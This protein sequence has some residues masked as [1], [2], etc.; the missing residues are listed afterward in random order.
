MTKNILTSICVFLALQSC[1]DTLL[2]EDIDEQVTNIE[3][4]LDNG[5]FDYTRE[6]D[7]FKVVNP[8]TPSTQISLQ[9]GDSLYFYFAQYLFTSTIGALYYT[10]IEHLATEANMDLMGLSYEPL[11]VK[12]GTTPLIEGYEIGL[13]GAMQGDTLTLFMTS[14]LAYGDKYISTLDKNQSI[15]SV[16]IIEKIVK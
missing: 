7:L 15:A 2:Q 13:N 12:Y 11:A 4:Y 1:S 10:N 16:V 6:G 3:S 5:K 8:V 14:E 9:E